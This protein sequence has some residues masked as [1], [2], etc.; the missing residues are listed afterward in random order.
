MKVAHSTYRPHAIKRERFNLKQLISLFTEPEH[1]YP[2]QRDHQKTLKNR[3]HVHN[4]LIGDSRRFAA[5]YVLDEMRLMGIDGYHRVA[6]VAAGLA[7][8]LNN[9]PPV[10]DTFVVKTMAEANRL[11]EQ[12]NSLAAAKKSTCWFTSG[13]REAGCL[14][15]I[16][17]KLVWTRGK[18]TA[19]QYAA[20]MVGSA[21]TKAATIAVVDGIKKVDG[22]R[23]TTSLEIAGTVGAYYA[24]TLYCKDDD[25]SETF[26]RCVNQAVFA[27]MKPTVADSY[28][29]A[30][31]SMLATVPSKTGGVS[32]SAAFHAGLH[33]FAQFAY[34][35]RRKSLRV[36]LDEMNLSLFKQLMAAL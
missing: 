18:A 28:I 27:P 22:W 4:A 20:G 25:V 31:R 5:V 13:L 3:K 9:Q 33:A 35:K 34:A 30:Y 15:S 16:Q 14:K 29:T 8:F 21:H 10:V 26:I 2:G 11:F 19:V 6:A 7:Y 24:I 32:N 17:S 23:L 36:A 1:L 12:F